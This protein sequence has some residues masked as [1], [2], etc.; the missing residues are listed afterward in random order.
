MCAG[1]DL[2]RC[3]WSTLLQLVPPMNSPL[4]A[5]QSVLAHFQLSL[6][7]WTLVSDNKHKMKVLIKTHGT[8][9]MQAKLYTRS[10]YSNRAVS[11][12]TLLERSPLHLCIYRFTSPLYALVLGDHVHIH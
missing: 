5:S 7:E 9:Q 3:R 10:R 4:P 12:N 6:G 2:S 1:G 8:P 11:Q